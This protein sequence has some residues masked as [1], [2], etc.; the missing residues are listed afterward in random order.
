MLVPIILFLLGL[1]NK[2]PSVRASDT[3]IDVARDVTPE[4]MASTAVLAMGPGGWNQLLLADWHGR[5]L[6]ASE[7]LGGEVTN[8]DFKTLENAAYEPE[9]RRLWQGKAVRVR[10][11]FAPNTRN[12]RVFNLARFSIQCCAAD[13][14]QLNVII[15]SKESL[16]SIQAGQWVEVTGKVEFR[17]RDGKYYTLMIIPGKK[18]LKATAP[19]ANPYI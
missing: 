19:D 8:I 16:A 18:A 12:D 10:G 15:I 11:Q 14:V 17:E 13:A 4:A 9:R 5:I 2:G 6:A 1:P 3:N 7:G